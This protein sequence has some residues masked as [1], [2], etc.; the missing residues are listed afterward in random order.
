M[1]TATAPIAPRSTGLA[2]IDATHLHRL[3]MRAIAIVIL[4][5][6]SVLVVLAA[7][8]TA[9]RSQLA[10]G[11]RTTPASVQLLAQPR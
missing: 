11:P 10:P 6:A 9:P 5:V 2:G 7:N 3:P 4:C 8:N 1:T